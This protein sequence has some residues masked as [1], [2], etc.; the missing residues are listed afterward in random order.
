[1]NNNGLKKVN[2]VPQSFFLQKQLKVIQLV[3]I[4]FSVFALLL[5]T[6]LC[7]IKTT[8]LTSVNKEVKNAEK[9]IAEAD[10]TTLQNLKNRLD[11][12]QAAS[13][14]GNFNTIPNVYEDMTDFLTCVVKNMPSTM[15]LDSI[16]GE[17]TTNG[18][19]SYSFSFSSSERGTIPKFL[20]DLQNES[21]LKYVNV[22]AITLS[23]GETSVGNGTNSENVTNET[24]Q[25]DA[26]GNWTFTLV[27]KTKGG[28]E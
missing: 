17:F 12:L 6:S 15:K 5:V 3:V 2:L 1:M 27:V 19:Y 13:D 26:S 10:F 20:Q 25:Q 18:V 16:D 4:I 21:I 7:F 11:A 8:E 23:G 24:V 9:I 28:V 14:A 22:S